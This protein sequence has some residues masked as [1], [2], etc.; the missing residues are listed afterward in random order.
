M[1]SL[2]AKPKVSVILPIRN[3]ADFIGRCLRSVMGN[4]VPAERM[5]ILV[6]DGMSDDGTREI[7]RSL[8]AEDPRIRL[9]DNTRRTVPF[10][11]NLGLAESKGDIIIRIDGHTTITADYVEQCVRTF[12]EHPDVWRVGGVMET[13]G[14]RYMARVIAA[15][16]SNPVGVGGG[17]WRIATEEGYAD[18]VAFPTWARWVFDKVGLYDEQL[19]RNQDSDLTQRISQ[20]GG[21][22]YR[23]PRMQT[24]YYS[25]GTL[26]KLGRQHYQYGLWGIRTIQKHGK[27]ANLRRVA[28]LI[29]V[30]VWLVLI[31]G[32]LLWRPGWMALSGF[33]AIY[34]LGLAYAFFHAAVRN[35]TKV[36]L[37]VPVACA[38]MHFTYGAGLLMGVIHWMVLRGRFIPKPE[39][40]KLSR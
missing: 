1:P 11:M 34:V 35:G 4:D 39:A 14:E 5:E 28:P 24:V 23:N 16:M 27:P 15:A 6:V 21:I 30:L 32:A 31:A 9:L 26:G 2:P 13:V 19:V 37:L 38:V 29:F 25:R 12:V 8:A 17:N 36:A 20:A 3:E 10:A 22:T 33:A 40:H 7:V 18:D